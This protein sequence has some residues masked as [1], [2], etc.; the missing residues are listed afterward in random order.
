MTIPIHNKNEFVDKFLTPLSR[1]NNSCSLHLKDDKLT[2]LVA[3][4]D[5]SVILNAIWKFD[6][7]NDENKLNIPDLNK[8]IKVL[9]CIREEYVT[10]KINSNNISYNE[11]GIKFK[12][13]LLED[14]ILSTPAINIEKVKALKYDTNFNIAGQDL[15][16]LIKSSTFASETDK[17]YIRTGDGKVFSEL[18]DKNKSNVDSIELVLSPEFSGSEIDN[19]LALS[20]EIIRIV[21]CNRFG[22]VATKINTNLGV[23]LFELNNDNVELIYVASGLAET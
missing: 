10:L 7:N 17:L 11:K 16:S 5:A 1:I 3:T 15:Q 23:L 6:A 9:D 21:S 13:H 20:F 18:T 12:Y 4:P 14:G 8:L 19:A 2:A 22:N